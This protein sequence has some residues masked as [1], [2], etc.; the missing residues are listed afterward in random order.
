MRFCKDCRFYKLSL[1]DR[2]K[3]GR[4]F[5]ECVQSPLSSA[6]PEVNLVTGKIEKL[7]PIYPFAY[8]TRIHSCGSSAKFWESKK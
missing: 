3:Y 6:K 8:V 2:L 4:D 1:W 7:T 5:G